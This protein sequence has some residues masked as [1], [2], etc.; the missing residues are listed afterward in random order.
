[1]PSTKDILQVMEMMTGRRDPHDVQ[2]RPCLVQ[3]RCRMP[4]RRQDQPTAPGKIWEHRDD[5][6]GLVLRL[7]Q[8]PQREPGF[9]LEV[10]RTTAPLRENVHLP[11]QAVP[12]E[13]VVLP[14]IIILPGTLETMDE[15]RG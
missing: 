6:V 5:P 11:A 13:G 9:H 12:R 15:S 8:N 7:A 10:Q 3:P 1:M 2:P 14:D 4:V